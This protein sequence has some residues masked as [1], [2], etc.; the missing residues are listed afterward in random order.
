MMQTEAAG[1]SR[2]SFCDILFGRHAAPRRVPKEGKR[3][4]SRA[5]IRLVAVHELGVDR[6]GSGVFSAAPATDEMP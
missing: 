2:I 1:F 3:T 6:R 4:E 5:T